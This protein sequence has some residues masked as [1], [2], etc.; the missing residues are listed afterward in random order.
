MKKEKYFTKKGVEFLLMYVL[1]FGRHSTGL[2]IFTEFNY[3]DQEN[4]VK[5][6]KKVFINRIPQNENN[7]EE[8][9]FIEIKKE[10]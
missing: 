7:M 6:L 5:D 10:L 9:G 3:K 4:F 8:D 1:K 2:P